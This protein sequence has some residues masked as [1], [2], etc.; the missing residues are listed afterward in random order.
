MNKA[1]AGFTAA[2][3]LLGVSACGA[4]ADTTPVKEVT[5]QVCLDALDHSDELVKLVT[6]VIANDNSAIADHSTASLDAAQQKLEDL[7]PKIKAASDSWVN[8]S[9]QCRA[10]AK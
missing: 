5:P 8:A 1:I 7:R 6:Q 3:L 4:P 10:K 2:A 9:D